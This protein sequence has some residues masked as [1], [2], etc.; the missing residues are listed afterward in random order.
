MARYAG[1]DI[2]ARDTVVTDRGNNIQLSEKR[3][4]KHRKYIYVDSN[5]SDLGDAEPC[6]RCNWDNICDVSSVLQG[7]DRRA[8]SEADVCFFPGKGSQ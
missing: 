1:M 3:Y 7:E 5:S 2:A 8:D 4:W 6:G